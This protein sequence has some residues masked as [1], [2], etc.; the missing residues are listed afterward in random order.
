M[1]EYKM[2]TIENKL[3]ETKIK[4]SKMKFFPRQINSGSWIYC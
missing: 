4:H 1:N 2:K 3:K